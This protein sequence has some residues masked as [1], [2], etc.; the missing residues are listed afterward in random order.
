MPNEHHYNM[1]TSLPGGCDPRLPAAGT[2]TGQVE[3]DK[4]LHRSSSTILHGGGSHI[5]PGVFSGMSRMG[6][7]GPK[8]MPGR[9][10]S[11][12][13]LRRA[14]GV[15][16]VAPRWISVAGAGGFVFPAKHDDHEHGLREARHEASETHKWQQ[17]RRLQAE[18][19][20]LNMLSHTTHQRSFLS[21]E[22]AAHKTYDINGRVYC[23]GKQTAPPPAQAKGTHWLTQVNGMTNEF[24]VVTNMPTHPHIVNRRTEELDRLKTMTAGMTIGGDVQPQRPVD[25]KDMPGFTRIRQRPFLGVTERHHSLFS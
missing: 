25:C 4:T 14:L 18:Q 19:R 7:G 6:A 8:S 2:A 17:T 10:E 11:Q 3:V 12:P 23:A 13:E 22:E 24:N 20:T 16:V 15:D 1:S 9:S 21:K 5:M